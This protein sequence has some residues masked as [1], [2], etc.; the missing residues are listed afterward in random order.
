MKYN[1]FGD[2]LKSLQASKPEADQGGL[3]LRNDDLDAIG[4]WAESQ[5]ADDP[6]KL[7]IVCRFCGRSPEADCDCTG[8]DG[9]KI[10]YLKSAPA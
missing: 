9:I 6:Q 2:M 10:V 4:K 8:V 3:V 1:T 5:T 7:I